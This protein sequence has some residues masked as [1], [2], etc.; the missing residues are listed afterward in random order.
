MIRQELIAADAGVTRERTH[1]IEAEAKAFRRLADTMVNAPSEILQVCADVALELCRAGGSGISLYDGTGNGE[2]IFRWV[3]L[4][5]ELKHHLHCTRPRYYSS[6]GN[7]VDDGASAFMP[8]PELVYTYLDV[9]T[10][11]HDTLLSPLGESGSGLEATLWVVSQDLARKFDGEDARVI[12]QIAVFTDAALQMARV[13]DE[14]R[15]AAADK[16][17]LFR[18]LEH[19]VM[20]TLQITAGLLRLQLG[21][22]ADPV[23]RDA[24]EVARQR[25]LAMGQIHRISGAAAAGDLVATIRSVCDGLVGANHP[26]CR[27]HLKAEENMTVPLHKAALVAMIVNELVTNAIKHA[28]RESSG[29]IVVGLRRTGPGRVALSVTDD[30]LALPPETAGAAKAGLGLKLVH[31]LAR[32]LGGELIVEQAAKCFVVAFPASNTQPH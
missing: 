26:S 8:R 14:A 6:C 19:R 4:A 25:V 11:F 13:V 3:A 32:Q 23:A 21:G 9:G 29:T 10:P 24:I 16:D 28:F 27:V 15:T 18:E 17:V 1:D 20:N 31:D 22:V 30:G 5:G 2:E 7:C 12:Q